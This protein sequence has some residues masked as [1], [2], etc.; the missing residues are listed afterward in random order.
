MKKI[1]VLSLQSWF[2]ISIQYTG[3]IYNAFTIANANN[4]SLTDILITDEIVIIPDELLLSNKA[5]QY[6]EARNLK[7]ATGYL[8]TTSLNI[9]T[10]I[11]Y[12]AV[13]T[14]FIIT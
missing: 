1:K 2:D 4:R 9:P 13:G 11:G 5:I 14:D 7:P 8:G 6:F 3:N 12:M 10:G